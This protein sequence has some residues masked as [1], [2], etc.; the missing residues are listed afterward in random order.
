V[1]SITRY[2]TQLNKKAICCI[3]REK[4]TERCKLNKKCRHVLVCRRKEPGS[5]LRNGRFWTTWLPRE[6]TRWSY[7]LLADS[8]HRVNL[9]QSRLLLIKCLLDIPARGVKAGKRRGSCFPQLCKSAG[10]AQSKFRI[11]PFLILKGNPYSGSLKP[12]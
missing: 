10:E 8:I 5:F 7:N 4:S 3:F 1:L 6:I 2:P 9:V 12:V 11:N